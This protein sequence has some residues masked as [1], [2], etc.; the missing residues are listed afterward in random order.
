M[1][2]KTTRDQIPPKAIRI[3]DPSRPMTASEVAD[4]MRMTTAQVYRQASEGR[5]PAKKIAGRYYFPTRTIYELVGMDDLLPTKIEII[6]PPADR[7]A[8]S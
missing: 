4:L 1:A 5:I 6:D 8:V 2:K 7:E 3:Y